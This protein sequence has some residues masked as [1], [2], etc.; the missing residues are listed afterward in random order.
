MAFLSLCAL[1]AEHPQ[2]HKQAFVTMNNIVYN[3]E[4]MD[5]GWVGWGGYNKKDDQQQN[6]LIEDL[7]INMKH[8]DL[9]SATTFAQIPNQGSRCSCVKRE[10]F[11]A[12]PISPRRLFGPHGV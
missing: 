2:G 5:V 11:D 4:A 7:Q 10:I 8:R 6:L 1:E 3:L 9:I 12:C